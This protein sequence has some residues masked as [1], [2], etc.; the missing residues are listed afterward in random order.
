[1]AE[2]NNLYTKSKEPINRE[3]MIKPTTR[4]AYDCVN[5]AMQFRKYRLGYHI[6][7]QFVKCSTS[8]AANYRAANLAQS[9]TAFV[10]KLSIVIEESNESTIWM[11]F[12]QSHGV[13]KSDEVNKLIKEENEIAM[14]FISSRKSIQA[15]LNDSRQ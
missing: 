1:M 6:Q 9:K 14:I 15:K 5:L 4:F 2:E 11:E 7:N 10:A 3:I 8:V 12:A 13:I